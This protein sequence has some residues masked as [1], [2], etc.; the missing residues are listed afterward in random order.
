MCVR[1]KWRRLF[2]GHEGNANARG[3]VDLGALGEEELAVDGARFKSRNGDGLV[4][5]GVRVGVCVG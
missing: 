3:G 4:R 5:V 1:P 2:G